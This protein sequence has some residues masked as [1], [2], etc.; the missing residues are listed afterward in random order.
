[1]ALEKAARTQFVDSYSSTPAP[2][3]GAWRAG[4]ARYNRE[5]VFWIDRNDCPGCGRNTNCLHADSS[6]DEFGPA[7]ICLDCAAEMHRQQADHAA[8]NPG[9]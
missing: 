4:K 1:M 8:G 9:P 7:I 5:C 3:W 2:P 6:E